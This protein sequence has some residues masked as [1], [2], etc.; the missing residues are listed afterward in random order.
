[1]LAWMRRDWNPHT[2]LVGMQNSVAALE[3]FQ[4][5]LRRLNIDLLSDPAIPLLV[6]MQEN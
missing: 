2:L 6:Y 1:M 4:L 5:F 3:K